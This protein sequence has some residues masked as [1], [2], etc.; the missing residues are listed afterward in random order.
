M[1]VYVT[2]V[3]T[4]ADA[5]A[6]TRERLRKQYTFTPAKPRGLP[7]HVSLP[8]ACLAASHANGFFC[9]PRDPA[10]LEELRSCGGTVH[11]LQPDPSAGQPLGFRGQLDPARMQDQAVAACLA[12]LKRNSWGGGALLSLPP[13]YGKTACAL[14]VTVALGVKT[15]VLV[16]TKVLVQQWR[17][18]IEAFVDNARVGVVTAAKVPEDVGACT[19]VI[20][21]LQTVLA[22]AKRGK[23][24]WVDSLRG[25]A[26]VDETHHIC[27][28]TLSQA[29]ATV[30]SR[31]RLGLSA[32]PERKDG[33]HPMLACLVGPMAFRCERQENPDVVVR[34]LRHRR[35][36]E[37]PPPD[38]FV[39]QVTQAA[40]DEAR[41]SN[42]EDA[43]L[44]AHVEGRCVIV[45]SDRLGQLADFRRRLEGGHGIATHL[46]VGGAKSGGEAPDM[47]AGRPV[48]L[49]TYAYAA[50]GMDIPVLNACILATPRLDVKQCVGRILRSTAKDHRP[51][52][53]DVC[54]EDMPLLRRQ[55]QRR[56]A[57]Y[58]KTIEAGGLE[59]TILA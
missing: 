36:A 43:I 52:V 7:S 1:D 37:A 4:L 6:A 27:A 21:M 30:G 15:L 11:D 16:H 35:R 40:A 51:L 57:F 3:I 58:R 25:L 48:V 2:Q 42:L 24:G 19:H 14:Y 18:R 38:T 56:L 32:T 41:Q 13:G 50:E 33:L 20:V 45:M 59:A 53:V 26:I 54:D 29:M 49:A 47:A 34:V 10:L 5:D 12:S 31:Y 22:Q 44:K 28:R 46:A 55:F 8:S 39:G 23:A 17:E 9:V